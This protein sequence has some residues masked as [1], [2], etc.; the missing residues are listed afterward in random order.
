MICGV[1]NV[2][3]REVRIDPVVDLVDA[4]WPDRTPRLLAPPLPSIQDRE[5]DEE[6]ATLKRC[7]PPRCVPDRSSQSRQNGHD[8]MANAFRW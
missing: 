2:Y 4:K 8:L 7:G 6:W 5:L 1:E 3:P